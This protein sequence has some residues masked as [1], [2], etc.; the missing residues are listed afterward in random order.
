MNNHLHIVCLDVPW[1]ADY[2]GAIDMMNRIMLFKKE[3]VRIHL[4]YFSYNERGM[5]NELNQFCET[6]HVYERKKGGRGFSSKLPYIVAS[7][8][9]ED[10]VKALNADEHPILLEG[11]HCTG[12]LPRLDLSSRKVVVRMHNEESIY[13]KEL[14]GAESSFLK[15][16]FFLNE[17]RLIKKYSGQLS[18]ECVYA[19]I[20]QEDAGIFKED[21]HLPHVKYLPAFPAWQEVKA[22]EGMGN[23]CLYHGNLSV[24]ENEKAAI[25]LLQHVFMK[26]RKPFVIAGKKPSRRLQKIAH[27]CQHTCLVADPSETEMNDLVRKAHINVLPCFN[28]RVTGIRL[29]L[30]HALF[31]G[32][33]CVVN[34]PMVKGT[35]LEGACH[36]GTTASAFASIIAQLY[37]QPFGREEILI[38]KQL[39]GDVYNNEKNLQ[40][41]IQYLW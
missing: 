39:L 32:R 29:K 1:P 38:R 2:G 6:I 20:S 5:P 40:Q 21:Y 13:Y 23:L 11:L 37:H 10:L 14:A 19:C 15:K 3:G 12:V 22:E 35:G 18:K 33:H 24:P 41:L 28:H 16:I 31:E 9:N 8:M 17:S 25:W 36:T 7:R 4:H 30:L 26:I 34:E 27:L